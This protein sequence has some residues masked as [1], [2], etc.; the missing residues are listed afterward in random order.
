MIKPTNQPSQP[1]PQWTLDELR[2]MAE[3][4]LDLE[5]VVSENGRIRS[6]PD[7]RTLRYYTTIGL[8]SRPTEFRG[9]TA[10]Y[11]R[12]HLAQIVTIKRLQASGA[13]LSDIQIRLTGITPTE[14]EQ[15]AGLPVQLPSP[16][17][18]PKSGYKLHEEPIPTVDTKKIPVDASSH[19]GAWLRLGPG[20]ALM[21]PAPFSG[22]SESLMDLLRSA[23]PLLDELRRQGL[24]GQDK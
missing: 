10:L 11:S 12:H 24:I 9:R 17:L 21:L 2:T 14:L 7:E 19:M 15:L 22:N 23:T 18:L 20:V 16:G 8:L 1:S 6:I 5:G 3:E 4:I 13:S